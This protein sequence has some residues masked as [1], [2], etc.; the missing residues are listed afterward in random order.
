[1]L[2]SPEK[3]KPT[4]EQVD[5][6]SFIKKQKRNLQVNALAGSG[7]TSTI[8]LMMEDTREP[9]LYMAFNKPVVEEAIERLPSTVTITTFNSKGLRCWKTCNGKADTY[10]KKMYDLIKEETLCPQR[11]GP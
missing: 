11:I 8:E 2:N 10:P 1:M 3:P 9:T 7:K 4:D 6:C 5:I